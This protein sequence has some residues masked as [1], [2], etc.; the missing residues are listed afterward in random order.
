MALRLD[1]TGFAY[2]STAHGKWVMEPGE[3]EIRIGA[4][5]RDIRL[6]ERIVLT[7]VPADDRD[8]AAPTLV[9]GRLEV[10]DDTFTAM[11]GKPIPPAD[12]VRPFHVN[13]TFAEI[14]TTWLGRKVANAVKTRFVARMGGEM[15][16][17]TRRMVEAMANDMPLRQ[18]VLF[19]GGGVGFAQIEALVA[20]LNGRYVK[21]LGLLAH[22]CRD[23]SLVCRAI[24]PSPDAPDVGI[25][26]RQQ[27]CFHLPTTT[28]RRSARGRRNCP[29]R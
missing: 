29:E 3:Y 16:A 9:E 26:Q 8:T 20:V 25:E 28:V 5:S 19:S 15:D 21:A 4:S 6:H 24:V 22:R 1:E 7:G 17:A 11:L 14:S 18:L 27:R 13:S 23:R 12:A 2:F 10:D